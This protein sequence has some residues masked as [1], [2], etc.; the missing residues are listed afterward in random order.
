MHFANVLI[1][2]VPLT[3]SIAVTRYI[4]VYQEAR[5]SRLAS[6]DHL[7]GLYNRRFACEMAD[8]N[9]KQALR[10]R[11]SVCFVLGDIDHFKNINDSYGHDVGDKILKEVSQLFSSDFRAVDIVSRWGGEEFL[12]VLPGADGGAAYKAV[13]KIR[14][15]LNQTVTVDSGNNTRLS[16]SFGIAEWQTGESMDDCVK[17]ADDALYASKENG[18]NQV[19][20]A[21][22]SSDPELSET[23]ELIS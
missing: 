4:T 5:L 13:D 7:T 23:I 9:I 17:R 11:T 19:T 6:Q 15:T 3:L 16:M 2:G 22:K 8:K 10:N 14:E 1:A 21:C 18:R 20:L 12:I